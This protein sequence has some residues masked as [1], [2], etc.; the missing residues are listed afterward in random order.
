L[1]LAAQFTDSGDAKLAADAK[2]L[3]ALI[4][5]RREEY[6]IALALFRDVVAVHNDAGNW[7][8][9]A[10]AATLGGDIESGVTGVPPVDLDG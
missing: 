1:E 6:D 5:F 10:T 7:F 3:V 9:I 8:N 2:K 4:R